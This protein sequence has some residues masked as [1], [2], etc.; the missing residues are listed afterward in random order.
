[1]AKSTSTDFVE[2]NMLLIEFVAAYKAYRELLALSN[3]HN[4]F[5][6]QGKILTVYTDNKS[7]IYVANKPGQT[8]KSRLIRL[9]Y[10]GLREACDARILDLIWCPTE[11]MI[12]DI[13]TKVMGGEVF[14]RLA[15]MVLGRVRWSLDGSIKWVKELVV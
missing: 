14:T 9:T 2:D 7:T 6:N 10:W 1:M 3:L 15:D 11:R 4:E 5:N 8:K 12:A 13:G